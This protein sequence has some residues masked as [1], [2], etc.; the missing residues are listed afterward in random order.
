MELLLGWL[1]TGEAAPTQHLRRLEKGKENSHQCY[2]EGM[3]SG[4]FLPCLIPKAKQTVVQE[5]MA[6]SLLKGTMKFFMFTDC[7]PGHRR[8]TL[9]KRGPGNLTVPLR[10]SCSRCGVS[11]QWAFHNHHRNLHKK[12]FHGSE[13][14]HGAQPFNLNWFSFSIFLFFFWQLEY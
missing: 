2:G 9:K 7:C 1:L 12:E 5:C 4:Q 8:K 6:G 14:T 3:F 13:N 10:S 11:C